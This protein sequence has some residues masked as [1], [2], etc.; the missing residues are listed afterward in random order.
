[1]CAAVDQRTERIGGLATHRADDSL[2][3]ASVVDGVVR[4]HAGDDVLHR[5]PPDVVGVDMLRVFDTETPVALA[6]RFG[7]VVVDVEQ[8]ADRAVAD[9]VHHD[10]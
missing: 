4:L 3:P 10:V 2:R 8:I 5:E 1:M 7:H 9:R 6:V